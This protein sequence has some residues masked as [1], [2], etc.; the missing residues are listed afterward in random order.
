MEYGRENINKLTQTVLDQFPNVKATASCIYANGDEKSFIQ[1]I[2]YGFQ[3]KQMV[4]VVYEENSGR[5]IKYTG[6]SLSGKKPENIM[7]FMLDF[8]NWLKR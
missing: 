5:L 3:E 2:F 6:M 7:D 4:K 8:M 1:L